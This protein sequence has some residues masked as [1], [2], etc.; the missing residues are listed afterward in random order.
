MKYSLAHRVLFSI[1]FCLVFSHQLYATTHIVSK[2]ETLGSIAKSYSL[3]V[4]EI[5]NANNLKNANNVKVGQKL[6]IPGTNLAPTEYIVRKGDTLGKIAKRHGLSIN[7]IAKANNLKNKKIVRIGQKLV[8]PVLPSQE[9]RYSV[10]KGDTLEIIAQQH[11]VTVSQMTAANKLTNSDL[12]AVGQEL[13]IPSK[14]QPLTT[15]TVRKGDSLAAIA[16]N[17][18]ITVSDILRHNSLSQPN[19][20]LPGQILTIPSDKVIRRIPKHPTLPGKIQKQIS[21]AKIKKGRWKHIIIHHS[22]MP[23]G[24]AKGLDRF[25]REERHME[26]GLAY[27]FLIGNGRGMGNGEIFISRRWEQQLDGGHVKSH[28]LNQ[29]SIGICLVGNFEKSRPNTAQM[30]SLEGLVRYL[31][32]I[33]KLPS[34]SVTTHKII[35]P[36]HTLCPGKNFPTKKFRAAISKP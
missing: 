27:H 17:Y 36:N 14:Q 9:I 28:E 29:T 22:A 3:T 31:M 23:I 10:K 12:L 24:S 5:A 6:I 13:I 2:G 30:K 1:L 32:T 20:I 4:K 18:G 26:N 35:H 25:H 8:I 34:S 7:Q 11:G 15:Y 19:T 21:K 33:T 16:N